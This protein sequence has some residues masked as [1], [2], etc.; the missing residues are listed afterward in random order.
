VTTGRSTREPLLSATMLAQ[1]LGVPRRW[2]YAQVEAHDMPAYRP[3]GGRKLLFELSA[4]EAWLDA[5]RSGDWSAESCADAGPAAGIPSTM[6][7]LQSG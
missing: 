2:I 4:V 7:K 1:T 5:Y 3:P 6:Q